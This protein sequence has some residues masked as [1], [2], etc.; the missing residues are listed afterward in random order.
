MA[1][2][3]TGSKLISHSVAAIKTLKRE[4]HREELAEWSLALCDVT[5]PYCI[6]LPCAFVILNESPGGKSTSQSD[7]SCQ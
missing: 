4:R 5:D 1:T 2:E 6:Y 7:E 3:Q